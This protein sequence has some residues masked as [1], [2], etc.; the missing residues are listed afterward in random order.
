M[1]DSTLVNWLLENGGPIVRYRTAVELGQPSRTE[2][3]GLRKDLLSSPLVQSWLNRL[4]PG[5]IHNS[6]DT[7]FENAMGKLVEFG[8]KAGLTDFDKR[9]APFRAGF[10]AMLA[11]RPGMMRTLNA[12][13]LASGLVRAGY[14]HEDSVNEFL[15][16]RLDTLYRTIREAGHDIY[17]DAD[18]YAG[19]PGP[20]RRKD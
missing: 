3:N 4:T 13:I 12:V 14:E 2:E 18:S 10:S 19:I 6:K 11:G 20:W 8:L 16:D 5:R 7:D 17:V 15:L 1:T 9:T